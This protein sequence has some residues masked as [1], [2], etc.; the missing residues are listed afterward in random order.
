MGK[1][2]QHMGKFTQSLH[3]LCN[4]GRVNTGYVKRLTQYMDKFTQHVVKI[5]QLLHTLCAM[6][7]QTLKCSN[8]LLICIHIMHQLW[9]N[10]EPWTFFLVKLLNSLRCFLE[11]L[12]HWQEF[13]TTAGRTGRAKYQLW[14]CYNL[15]Q[16]N[17]NTHFIIMITPIHSK[18]WSRWSPDSADNLEFSTK[19]LSENAKTINSVR[20]NTCFW[21]CR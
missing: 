18:S 11:N 21:D 15:K 16:A 4:D 8:K 5:T 12:H 13:Y 7:V 1:F 14:S 19:R 20:E 9:L 6:I 17:L 2:T 10:Q 3:V